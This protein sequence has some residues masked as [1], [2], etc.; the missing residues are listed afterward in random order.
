MKVL[1][2][3]QEVPPETGWGGIG[4]FVAR[5]AP[6]LVEA[7]AEVTV[8][9]V[10][11]G[12]GAGVA[13][14]GGAR[15][16][17]RPLRR[18]RGVGRITGMTRTWERLTTA[19]AVDREV[20]RLGWEPDVVE[21][22]EWMA[23]G[24]VLARRSVPMV[25]RLHSSAAQI[26]PREGRSG[27]DVRW[28]VRLEEAAVR[29]ADVV[30]G[31]RSQ[32]AESAHLLDGVVAVEQSLPVPEVA[33]RPEPAGPPTV[34]AVGRLEP[35][36]CPEV[37]VEAMPALRRLVPDARLV[38]TGRDSSRPGR[39]SYAAWLRS[40]AE[41]LGVADAVD[42]RDLWLP[43]SEVAD[44]LGE[45]H[46][47]AVPSTWES[48]GYVAAEAAMVGRPVVASAVAGLLDVVDHGETGTTAAPGDPDAWAEAIAGYLSDP[49]LARA[50]GAHG[51]RRARERFGPGPWARRTL[52]IYRQARAVASG[53]AP[54]G[55]AA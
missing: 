14:L 37:L 4:S 9:S 5:A 16:V 42:V 33:V 32:L 35:R 27:R 1:L 13:D 49:D 26:Y 30:V 44:A 50:H 51:A 15:V 23:E 19:R 2:V 43:A 7:G 52:E 11:A 34:V 17:R 22:P 40:R 24:L 29:R 28:A 6:A 54:T 3:S 39:P 47:V 31:T 41:D 55:V 10:V 20:R 38:I 46:V 45:G 18:V 53:S 8:L 36:K 48:F 12:Q 21:C 25:V